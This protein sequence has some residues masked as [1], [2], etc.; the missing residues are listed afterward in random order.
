MGKNNNQRI[1]FVNSFT[2]SKIKIDEKK[3]KNVIRTTSFTYLKNLEE[4][5]GF[6][7]SHI[8]KKG[9]KISFFKYGPKNNWEKLITH[10]IREMIENSFNKE[11]KELN[12]L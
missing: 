2:K 11:M 7:E 10:D 12:Y 3:L 4:N 1:N 8:D 6:E 9:N 5:E